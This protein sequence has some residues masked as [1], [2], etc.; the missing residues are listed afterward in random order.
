VGE[1]DSFDWRRENIRESQ[2]ILRIREDRDN[3][4]KNDPREYRVGKKKEGLII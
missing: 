1:G 4:E 3:V 2:S